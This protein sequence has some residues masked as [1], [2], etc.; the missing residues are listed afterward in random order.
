MTN[1]LPTLQ[2]R[3][4][5]SLLPVY[6]A[7]EAQNIW[8]LVLAALTGA[9]YRSRPSAHFLPDDSFQEKLEAIRQRLLRGEPVQY[10]L[11]EAWFYDSPFYVNKQVLIPRPETEELVDWVIRE[12]GTKTGLNI[13]DVGSGSGCIPIILKRKIPSA[14]LTSCDISAGALEVARRNARQLKADILFL[15]LD[16]LDASERRHRLPAADIMISNPP[17]IPE[18]DQA[19]MAAHVLAYEPHTALFVKNDNPLIFYRALALDGKTRLPEGGLIYVEIDTNQAS[20]VQEVFIDAGFEVTLRQDLQGMDRM[21]RARKT[22][23]SDPPN[24]R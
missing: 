4:I 22:A 3:F 5:A 24:K 15:E 8:H 21:I 18:K 23:S 11:E 14:T 6:E 12:Q 1:P 2:S 10:I 19:M 13:L 17:Y 9:P 20:A 7:G 16:Y